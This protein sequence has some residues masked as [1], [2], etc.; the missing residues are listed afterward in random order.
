M[1]TQTIGP[2]EAMRDAMIKGLEQNGK[3][4]QGG[5]DHIR[6]HFQTGGSAVEVAGRFIEFLNSDFGSRAMAPG[7]VQDNVS[8]RHVASMFSQ[9]AP[10]RRQELADMLHVELGHLEPHRQ[11]QEIARKFLNRNFAEEWFET[12]PPAPEWEQRLERILGEHFRDVF[13]KADRQTVARQLG[14]ELG[15]GGSDHEVIERVAQAFAQ[16]GMANRFDVSPIQPGDDRMSATRW[17]P[18]AEPGPEPRNIDARY[19]L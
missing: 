8:L 11:A 10:G 18:P 6:N 13:T 4:A 7:A 3:L 9:V 16:Q 15:R 5:A 19:S 14:F 2:G 12:P 1:S 17:A